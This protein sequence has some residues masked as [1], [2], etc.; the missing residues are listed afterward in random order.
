MLDAAPFVARA[1]PA[2]LH[3]VADEDRA[4]LADDADGDLEIFL[5]WGNETA[6]ALN[7]LGHK[8]R[9]AAGRRRL[10]QILDV[11]GATDAA[12]GI[13]EAQRAPIAVG[14]QRVLDAGDL[15][16]QDTPGLLPRDRDRPLAAPGVAVPQRDDLLLAGIDLC[17]HDRGLVRFR[18]AGREEA[19]LELARGDLRQSL[20]D[21]HLLDSRVDARG[22]HQPRELILQ[23]LDELWMRMPDPRCQNAAEKIEVFAA[24]EVLDR[25]PVGLGD[26]HGFGV[27]VGDAGKQKVFVLLAYGLRIHQWVGSLF[28]NWPRPTVPTNSPS[29]AWTCPRTDTAAARPFCSQPS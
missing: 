11:L 3:L 22:V 23:A 5:G 9:R 24:V 1:A 12:V 17:Q 25:R 16:G 18:A 19:L 13:F 4:V 14:R 10:D 20:G 21:A 29:R 28:K 2:R 26:H 15:R 27:I 7:R 6:G 8:R